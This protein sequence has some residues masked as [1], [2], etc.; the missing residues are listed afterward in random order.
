MPERTTPLPNL[1][2]QGERGLSVFLIDNYDSF[3]YNLFQYLS[4]L[5][6]RVT[7]RRNDRFEPE[8][9]ADMGSDAIVIS[10]GPG[11]PAD[12]G[13][14]IPVIERYGGQLPILGVCLGH[15][16]IGESF[17]GRIIRA[18]SLFHGKV[19]EI[20]HNGE[21]LY[22]GLPNPLTATRY[23]SL[24]IDPETVPECLEVTASTVDG[25]IM[26]V[27]HREL[28][29]YGVQFHPESALTPEGK[30][31]LQNFLDHVV[32]WDPLVSAS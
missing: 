9:I 16:A 7:V 4:E 18:P 23:H 11:R 24:V 6:A 32:A 26:G 1:P 25:V 3:T 12:A 19:S 14:S 13:H 10:P 21:G 15:Q 30:P 5:G 28:P 29:I 17:G 20:Q 27:R 8:E 22:Q 31:L 2:P